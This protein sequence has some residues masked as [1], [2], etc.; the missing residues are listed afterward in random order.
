M[1]GD[2]SPEIC[3]L[4]RVCVWGGACVRACTQETK[5]LNQGGTRK[6]YFEVEDFGLGHEGSGSQTD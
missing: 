3:T 4:C 2:L 5:L 6:L 1:E